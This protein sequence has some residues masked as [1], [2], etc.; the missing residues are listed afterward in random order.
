MVLPFKD[1]YWTLAQVPIHYSI[2][3]HKQRKIV[4]YITTA[5]WKVW[6]TLWKL[7]I[8]RIGLAHH[9][10]VMGSTSKEKMTPFNFHVTIRCSYPPALKFKYSMSTCSCDL[11]KHCQDLTVWALYLNWPRWVRRQCQLHQ[12]DR[13]SHWLGWV[14]LPCILLCLFPKYITIRLLNEQ[15]NT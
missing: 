11:I 5:F 2:I 7:L 1:C 6:H 15:F 3:I 10:I 8:N 13:C 14:L 9:C 4:K 12:L